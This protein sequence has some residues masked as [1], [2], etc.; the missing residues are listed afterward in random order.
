MSRCRVIEISFHPEVMKKDTDI[1]E[2]F[3]IQQDRDYIS[4]FDNA[5]SEYLKG[6][7]GEPD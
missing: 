2:Q 7:A 3:R 5:M 1:Y 4:N 6:K